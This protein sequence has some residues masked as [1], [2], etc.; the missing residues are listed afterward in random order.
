MSNHDLKQEYFEWMYQLVCNDKYYKRLSYTKLLNALYDMEFIPTMKMDRNRAE[1]GHDFRYRFGYECGYSREY[2]QEYLDDSPCN[3]L[4]M[5][6]AL[7]HRVEEQIMDDTNYGDRTGQWFWNMIVSL[8]LGT[9]S[10]DNFDLDYVCYVIDIF[11]RREYEPNG[12]G[13]LF[14]VENCP[15]DLRDMEIW[16]Q[17]MWY[18][19]EV[20]DGQ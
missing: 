7:S 13:G 16:N 17:F 4:E 9:M 1:D 15:F 18:L 2:I 14:T 11:L 6:I 12:K 3:I 5:M 20:I 10:N 8:G 19:D